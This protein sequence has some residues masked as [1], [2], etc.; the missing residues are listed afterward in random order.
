MK[1]PTTAL[2][3]CPRCQARCI[4]HRK[5]QL[6]HDV[7]T[8]SAC[9]FFLVVTPPIGLVDLSVPAGRQYFGRVLRYRHS[10]FLL[11]HHRDTSVLLLITPHFPK[12]TPIPIL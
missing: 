10:R 8:T 6:P 2:D 3:R 12:S 7:K 9:P 4:P 5:M 11:A 1:P